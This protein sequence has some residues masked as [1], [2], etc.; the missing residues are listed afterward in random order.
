MSCAHLG[1]LVTRPLILIVPPLQIATVVHI[2]SVASR[3]AMFDS[4]LRGVTPVAVPGAL[5]V[6]DI[7]RLN[8]AGTA[9]VSLGVPADSAQRAYH[10]MGSEAAPASATG[11]SAC[12]DVWLAAG[13]HSVLLPSAMLGDK[14]G[15]VSALYRNMR[16]GSAIAPAVAA[17]S[18]ERMHTASE[19]GDS[20]T[21]LLRC[22]L[23]ISRPWLCVC[24]MTV[25]FI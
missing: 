8:L 12:V 15:F 1:R 3:S 14:V 7:A 16:P 23:S 5:G 25:F 18:L 11:A 20:L 21:K 17:A 19:S 22:V 24:T 2:T 13:A 4:L 10:P 6:S 9:L